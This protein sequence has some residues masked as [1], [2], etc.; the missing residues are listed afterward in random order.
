M[1]VSRLCYSDK[2]YKRFA[3]SIEANLTKQQ[4]L[5]F[6]KLIGCNSLE[7]YYLFKNNPVVLKNVPMVQ[8]YL[9]HNFITVTGHT[10]H[11]EPPIGEYPNFEEC[12]DLQHSRQ[13]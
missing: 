9:I 6:S 7:A 4:L 12:W 2:L 1:A 3:I 11:I 8:T 13:S 10:I 5:D